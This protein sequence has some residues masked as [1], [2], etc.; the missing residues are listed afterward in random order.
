MVRFQQ[1]QAVITKLRS[2]NRSVAQITISE[3]PRCLLFFFFF[4]FWLGPATSASAGGFPQS[5][6]AWLPYRSPLAD[7]LGEAGVKGEGKKK[8]ESWGKEREKKKK[9]T[10]KSLTPSWIAGFPPLT[11][12]ALCQDLRFHVWSPL[13]Q[14]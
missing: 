3:R 1:S 12:E 5:R 13:T 7:R 10:P 2:H 4:F 11:G 14:R 9:G 8:Q 6:S